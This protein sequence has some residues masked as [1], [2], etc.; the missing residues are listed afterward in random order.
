MVA[1]VW[2]DCPTRSS[3][4][5]SSAT[6]I[7]GLA[8]IHIPR[9]NRRPPPFP[10]APPRTPSPNHC[11]PLEPTSAG[12]QGASPGPE[13]RPG[14]SRSPGTGWV[15]RSVDKDQPNGRRMPTLARD[16]ADYVLRAPAGGSGSQSYS[17]KVHSCV[18]IGQ[19]CTPVGLAANDTQVTGKCVLLAARLFRVPYRGKQGICEGIEMATTCSGNVS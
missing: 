17:T 14:V 16:P 1:A 10:H 4:T 5:P 8:R 18:L 15:R 7:P 2:R 11:S 3:E 19:L 13:C 12:C 9:P 6:H